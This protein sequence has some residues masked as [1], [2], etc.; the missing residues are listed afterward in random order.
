MNRKKL[1]QKQIE[2]RALSVTTI[3]NAVITGAG[4]WGVFLDQSTDDV[5]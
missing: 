5:P 1:T 2:N 3:V 4:I